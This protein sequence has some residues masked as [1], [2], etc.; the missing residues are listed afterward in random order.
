MGQKMGSVAFFFPGVGVIYLFTGVPLA[1]PLLIYARPLRSF[2][3]NNKTSELDSMSLS[4]L[5]SYYT[6]SEHLMEHLW[7]LFVDT[8]SVRAV[9]S[10]KTK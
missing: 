9:E 4:T 7:P 3:R 2:H 8:L 1:A 5:Y 6:Q 10:K